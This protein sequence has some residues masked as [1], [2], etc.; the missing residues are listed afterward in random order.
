MAAAFLA[1]VL[2]PQSFLPHRA[3]VP[4]GVSSSRTGIIGIDS[5]LPCTED[6]LLLVLEECKALNDD[7]FGIHRRCAEIGITGDVELVDF[8]G[9]FVTIG[10]SGRFWHRR[11]TVLQRVGA[12]L[13]ARIPELVEVT[14]V[15]ANMAEDLIYNEDN[16]LVEDRRSPD[17]NGDREMMTFNGYDPDRRG[18]F[19]DKNSLSFFV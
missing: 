16:E 18:P 15:D 8:E 2:T 7:M 9:P 12:H 6:N 11:R 5:A 3:A 17:Y 1:A 10:L 13:S 19:P 4:R 14:L